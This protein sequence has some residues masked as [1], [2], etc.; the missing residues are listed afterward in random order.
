L[1]QKRYGPLRI[2]KN[3]GQKVFQIKLL[4]ELMIYNMLNED[5]LTQY[6]ELQFKKQHMKP[7]PLPD[8]VNKEEEYKVE[9]VRNHRKQR[10]NI[11][12]L[13]Y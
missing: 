8:I 2:L 10:C 3:I 6:K 13:V 7:V 5:L 4:K 12:F 1:D 11:Q 9:E